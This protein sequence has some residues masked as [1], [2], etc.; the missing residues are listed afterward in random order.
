MSFSEHEHPVVALNNA[1]LRFV[2]IEDGR[3]PGLGGVDLA[4]DDRGEILAEAKKRN[5]YVS[6]TQVT[7]CGTRFYLS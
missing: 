1:K 4:V 5:A 6:D 7:V 3:G 2:S